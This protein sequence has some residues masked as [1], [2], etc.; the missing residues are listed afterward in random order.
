MTLS[1]GARAVAPGECHFLVVLLFLHLQ[2]K[3]QDEMGFF[4]LREASGR[5]SLCQR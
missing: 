1:L 5:T 4:L 2:N 3:W